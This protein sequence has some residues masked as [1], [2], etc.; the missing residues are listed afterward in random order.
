MRNID[1]LTK[2]TQLR[3]NIT[4]GDMKDPDG[5]TKMNAEQVLK[6]LFGEK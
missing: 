6:D 3:W 4:D 1:Y 2:Y 5:Y